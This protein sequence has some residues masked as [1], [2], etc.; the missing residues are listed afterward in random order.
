MTKRVKAARIMMFT[1]PEDASMIAQEMSGVI[2]QAARGFKAIT[3]ALE[4]NDLEAVERI[5]RLGAQAMH[6]EHDQILDRCS[7]LLPPEMFEKAMELKDSP[8][9]LNQLIRDFVTQNPSM[10]DKVMEML[11]MNQ[12][13]PP[14][15]KEQMH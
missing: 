9:E 10:V 4:K 6:I 8:E 13:T 1:G 2:R 15:P 14:P 11:M 5:A 12:V 3:T 7:V